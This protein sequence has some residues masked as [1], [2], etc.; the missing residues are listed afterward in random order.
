MKDELQWNTQYQQSQKLFF[1]CISLYK[2][3]QTNTADLN[4]LET[5]F[6]IQ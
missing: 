6:K 5:L 1:P 2:I 4:L 3:F